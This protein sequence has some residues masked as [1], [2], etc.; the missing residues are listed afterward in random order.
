MAEI[1]GSTPGFISLQKFTSPRKPYGLSTDVIG[2]EA[3]Y[4]LQTMDLNRKKD[5]DLI[6]V[7][8]KGSKLIFRYIRLDCHQIKATKT[9][10]KYKVFV[11]YA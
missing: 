10:D 4:G 2:N 1:V 8:K 6:V 11:P 9:R 5:D 3:K 7:G